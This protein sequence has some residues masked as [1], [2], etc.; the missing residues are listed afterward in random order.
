MDA[1]SRRRGPG[2]LCRRSTKPERGGRSQGGLLELAGGKLG[3]SVDC[4]AM[5]EME[6]DA[7]FDLLDRCACLFAL[8]FGF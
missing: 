8:V 7:S 2:E 6:E 4:R 5:T 1:K 3:W